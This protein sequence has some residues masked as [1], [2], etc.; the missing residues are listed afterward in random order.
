M[1]LLP[2]R[3]TLRRQEM[4]T[5]PG[6]EMAMLPARAT[7]PGQEMALLPAKVT[8]PGSEMALLPAAGILGRVA[9]EEKATVLRLASVQARETVEPQAWV[10]TA[11]VWPLAAVWSRGPAASQTAVSLL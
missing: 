7:L 6:Q 4:A 8:L 3:A 10:P 11:T 5:L 1:A 9:V 2:A